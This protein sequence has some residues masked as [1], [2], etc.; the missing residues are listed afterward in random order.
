MSDVEDQDDLQTAATVVR[1]PKKVRAE[2]LENAYQRNRYTGEALK[3]IRKD[4]GLSSE[5]VRRRIHS[6]RERDHLAGKHVPERS[7]SKPSILWSEEL[8]RCFAKH[9]YIFRDEAKYLIEKLKLKDINPVQLAHKFKTKSSSLQSQPE[10]KKKLAVY[11]EMKF[12]MRD[13]KN[14]NLSKHDGKELQRK[15][16]LLEDFFEIHK[17]NNEIIEYDDLVKEIDLDSELVLEWLGIRRY[18]ES[19]K[20]PPFTSGI[21]YREISPRSKLT[22][23]CLQD[24]EKFWEEGTYSIDKEAVYEELSE[25][26]K[27]GRKTVQQWFTQRKRSDKIAKNKARRNEPVVNNDDFDDDVNDNMDVN[28][29]NTPVG[30]RNEMESNDNSNSVQGNQVMKR[31]PVTSEQDNSNDDEKPLR[32]KANTKEDI[33]DDESDDES[34]TPYDGRSTPIRKLAMIQYEDK[35]KIC[36]FCGYGHIP[37]RCPVFRT[38]DARWE[39][40]RTNRMC[41]ECLA[42]DFGLGRHQC[43]SGFPID[44][45]CYYCKEEVHNSALCRVPKTVVD[46]KYFMP[47]GPKD[48]FQRQPSPDPSQM[49]EFNQYYGWDRRPQQD[50][51]DPRRDQDLRGQRRHRERGQGPNRREI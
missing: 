20:P 44:F 23:S 2:V 18:L 36:S 19:K 38:A 21:N 9:P 30:G 14:H 8:Q 43:P 22:A 15:Y 46:T 41:Q 45:G 31:K 1:K 24:L 5:Q 25:K 26:H 27:M 40:L 4:T 13:Y 50:P 35:S 12:S 17:D 32:K 28:G 47:S 3:E 34:S 51:I 10:F 29:D 16:I 39:L 37:D 42:R 7:D 33:P 6:K 11:K 49:T 48:G